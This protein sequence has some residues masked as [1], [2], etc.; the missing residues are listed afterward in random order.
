MVDDNYEPNLIGVRV[1]NFKK[2]C[3]TGAACLAVGIL[4]T[5]VY[6]VTSY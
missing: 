4:P 3:M 2:I 1:M 5:Y 6:K